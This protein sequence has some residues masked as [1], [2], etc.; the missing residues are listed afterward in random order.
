MEDKK[1]KVQLVITMD[2][3]NRIT[4]SSTGGDDV[5]IITAVGILETAKMDLLATS[6]QKEQP[7]EELVEITLTEMDF[8]LDQSGYLEKQGK[9]VGD[10]SMMPSSLAILREQSHKAMK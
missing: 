1:I 4:I 9:K 10:K 5:S 7:K 6:S 3:S 8:A 2:D